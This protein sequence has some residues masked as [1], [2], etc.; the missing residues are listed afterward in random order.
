MAELR[1][2]KRIKEILELLNYQYVEPN[3][4]QRAK[5]KSLL[6]QA[7]LLGAKIRAASGKA[8]KTE[9]LMVT[10]EKVNEDIKYHN[11]LSLSQIIRSIEKISI[12]KFYNEYGVDFENPN[13]YAKAQGFSSFYAYHVR[14]RNSVSLVE[15]IAGKLYPKGRAWRVGDLCQ[16]YEGYKE[17]FRKAKMLEASYSRTLNYMVKREWIEK[18]NNPYDKKEKLF[19]IASK[20]KEVLA[21]LNQNRITNS[22]QSEVKGRG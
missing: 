16:Y 18:W 20:G 2:S 22:L 15:A 6:E 17:A 7:S 12:S 9:D 4:E 5:I 10:D 1:V 13:L 21:I 11:S 14:F 19:I 3:N 8:V